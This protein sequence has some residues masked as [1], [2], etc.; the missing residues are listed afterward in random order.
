MHSRVMP[1]H[2]TEPKGPFCLQKEPVKKIKQLAQ[3]GA[4]SL[5]PGPLCLTWPGPQ[6]AGSTEGT[7]AC[8]CCLL[9]N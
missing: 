9:N 2:D 3:K 5:W 1:V 4:L 8:R 7:A 6:L